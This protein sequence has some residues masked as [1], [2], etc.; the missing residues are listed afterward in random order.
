MRT[1]RELKVPSRDVDGSLKLGLG[2]G[3]V[4]ME[5]SVDLG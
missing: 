5:T 3:K 4:S 2:R 1:K